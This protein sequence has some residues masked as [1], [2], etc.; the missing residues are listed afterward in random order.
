MPLLP[1]AKN[2]FDTGKTRLGQAGLVFGGRSVNAGNTGLC[3]PEKTPQA[4]PYSE[5][6]LFIWHETP[7]HCSSVPS[8]CHNRAIAQKKSSQVDGALVRK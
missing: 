3:R 4:A 5:S 7:D 8:V 1:D 2:L 6:R